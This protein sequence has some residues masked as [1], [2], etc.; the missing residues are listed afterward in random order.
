MYDFSKWTDATAALPW[1]A[2]R[3]LH[4]T[5]S[6]VSEEKVTLVHGADYKNGSPC[7]INAAATM[8]SKING[9]GGGGKPSSFFGD[10][11]SEFDAI[12]SH[13]V[14]VGVNKGDGYVSPMA[15]D[16]LLAHFS[17]LRTPEV[18]DQVTEATKTEA[19]ANVTYREPSDDEIMR[20]WLTALSTDNCP[21]EEEQE[22]QREIGDTYEDYVQADTL[23]ERNV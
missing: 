16:V 20:D 12:N 3:A 23:K 8:L 5:L 17:P 13:L 21:T 2:Q 18:S 11:V 10:I 9:E 7:L 1:G 6:L 22:F 4:D 19:F 14:R 15:A